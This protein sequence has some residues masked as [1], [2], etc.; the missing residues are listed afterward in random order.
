MTQSLASVS[1]TADCQMDV[2]LPGPGSVLALLIPDR[3]DGDE[4]RRYS[5]FSEA[6]K[7]SDCC[8]ACEALWCGETHAHNAPQD[9]CDSNKL[10][11]GEL[12]HQVDEGEF[13][14]K[15]PNVED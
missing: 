2:N 10:G 8:E 5:T 3:C 14:H 9:D 15:L 7:E 4:S 1:Y 12:R 11:E 13:S 6:Q